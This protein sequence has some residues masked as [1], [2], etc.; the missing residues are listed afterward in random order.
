M[1][2]LGLVVSSERMSPGGGKIE[3]ASPLAGRLGLSTLLV[4]ETVQNAWDARDD[5]RG[6]D[7]VRFRIDGWDLDHQE[8]K[9]LKKLL[10]V[11]DLDRA[12]FMRAT[13]DGYGIVHPSEVLDR[14]SLRVLVVSDR[15]TVG[16]CGPSRSGMTWNPVRHGKV[17]KR[18]QQRFANFVRN[19]GRAASNIGGGDGGAFGVGKSAL[20]MA[21]ECGTILIHSRTTDEYGEPV[22]RFIGSIHGDFFD[23][24]G[25][26]YTGRHYIGLD[27]GDGVVEPLT[28][29]AARAASECLPL[30]SYFD[31]HGNPVD[32]TSIVIVAPLMSL[33]WDVEMNRIRDAVRWHVWPKRVAG[34]R[35]ERAGPDMEIGLSWN[36]NQ[37]ELVDPSDDPEI[38][39]YAKTLLDCARSRRKDEAFRDVVAMCHRPSKELGAVKFRSAGSSDSNAFHLTLTKEELESAHPDGFEGEVDDE[40]TVEFSQPWGQIALIRREPLLLVRYEEI[41]GP[42]E[43]RNEV[44]VFLSA[45]DPVVEAALTKAEPPAHDDWNPEQVPMDFM[46]YGKTF[47]RRTLAEIKSARL[48]LIASLRASS[49]GSR[50]GGEQDVSRRLSG[51]LFGG[52]GG[53]LGDHGGGGTG[54]NGGRSRPRATFGSHTT[55]RSAA[56]ETVHQLVLTL[57]GVG[58][59]EKQLR[60]SAEGTAQDNTG[61]M[62][63]GGMVSFDWETSDGHV[64]EGR[65]LPLFGKDGT[66]V[67]LV[68]R[69]VGDLRIRPKVSVEEVHGG[70]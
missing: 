21:S 58:E 15:N 29:P 56:G 37:V 2:T 12:G 33:P 24:D 55:S 10:P 62:D 60:L 38:G 17:L 44:G 46:G 47:V 1:K 18:G 27:D 66:Q 39:P 32:G 54:G 5:E 52:L 36:N 53:R 64:V 20:W 43:A 45:D 35:A 8:A 68:V 42:E 40:P 9:N 28:G 19:M 34:V 23:R 30:P 61:S 7:P 49:E 59:E 41:G 67:T 63:A 16:L 3:G 22:E 13:D 11:S 31:D 57:E 70:S 4:R 50:G 26:E 6:D 48:G 69:V 51:G 25:Y 14:R 65:D